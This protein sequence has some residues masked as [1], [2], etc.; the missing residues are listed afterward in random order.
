M[1]EKIFSAKDMYD[2]LAFK[3]KL[4]TRELKKKIVVVMDIIV[5]LL[6]HLMK[7]TNKN[8]AEKVNRYIHEKMAEEKVKKKEKKKN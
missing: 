2:A 3:Q 8:L 7:Y 6:I 4:C 5:I 1:D